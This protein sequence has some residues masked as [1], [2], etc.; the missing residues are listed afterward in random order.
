M[1]IFMRKSWDDMG[2][3]KE[4]QPNLECYWDSAQIG[5]EHLAVDTFT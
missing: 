3:I 5:L 4:W 1:R 2:R